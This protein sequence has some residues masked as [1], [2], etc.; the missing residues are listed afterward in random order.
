MRS[1][2]GIWDL[3]SHT[4]LYSNFSKVTIWTESGVNSANSSF[5]FLSPPVVCCL[6]CRKNLNV[7]H[8]WSFAKP[9]TQVKVHTVEGT[10]VFSKV[11]Y[12]CK[13]CSGTGANGRDI[14]Y[15]VGM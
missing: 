14:N 3:T 8:S 7:H 13:S 9:P 6:Y 1:D 12:R 10:S 15:H 4:P 5:R 11:A 2:S